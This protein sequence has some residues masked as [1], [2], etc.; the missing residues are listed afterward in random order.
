MCFDLESVA[1]RYNT[2]HS[3]TQIASQRNTHY[4]PNL[5]PSSARLVRRGRPRRLRH[6]RDIVTRRFRPYLSTRRPVPLGAL[7]ETQPDMDGTVTNVHTR[8]PRQHFLHH[9]CHRRLQLKLPP[10][11]RPVGVGPTARHN[12]KHSAAPS[13]EERSSVLSTDRP[14]S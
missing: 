2:I 9:A 14:C 6:S 10:T 11:T 12:R 4:L 3:V 7:R 13:C 8:Q 1:L 5:L